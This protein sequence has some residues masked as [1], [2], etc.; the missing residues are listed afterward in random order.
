MPS[1][2]KHSARQQWYRMR[3]P[4]WC[5]DDAIQ[6]LPLEAKGALIEITTRCHLS[7]DDGTLIICGQPIGPQTLDAATPNDRA[8]L[9]NLAEVLRIST[10]KARKLVEKLQKNG[11][12]AVDDDGV[13]YS[14]LLAEEREISRIAAEKGGKGGN[15]HEKARVE[16]LKLAVNNVDNPRE[17]ER[18]QRS[19][20]R[21]QKREKE[22]ARSR[23]P[24][25]WESI[26]K[27]IRPTVPRPLHDEFLAKLGDDDDPRELFEFYSRVSNKWKGKR[28]DEGSFDFWKRE[29][30]EWRGTTTKRQT[31]A[32]GR[33]SGQLADI[34]AWGGE[35]VND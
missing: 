28:V 20:Y 34:R 25:S 21:D 12:I 10:G 27:H 15:P 33:L 6:L 30:R 23:S 7:S 16:R 11:V 4:R 1:D 9:K 32:A 17:R 2:D 31:K 35:A 19:E 8:A 22:S 14:P 3:S 26:P 29:M 13:F 24:W 5:A 18:V